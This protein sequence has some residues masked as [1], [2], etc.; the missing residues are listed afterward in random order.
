MYIWFLFWFSYNPNN[1]NSVKDDINANIVEHF[2]RLKPLLGANAGAV[3]GE[4]STI[5][6]VLTLAPIGMIWNKKNGVCMY[7]CSNA[8]RC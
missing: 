5:T 6:G 3:V 2:L 1:K 8:Y 7:V 4:R